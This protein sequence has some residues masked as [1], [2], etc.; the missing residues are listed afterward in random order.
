MDEA[1]NTEYDGIRATAEQN[2]HLPPLPYPGFFRYRP[3]R[4]LFS[5]T[6]SPNSKLHQLAGRFCL[7]R[8]IYHS[9]EYHPTINT[10]KDAITHSPGAQFH[11]ESAPAH[12]MHRLL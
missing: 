4:H 9:A 7:S 12:A 8:S 10:L 5:A 1:R 2:Y 11:D 3:Q 6:Q